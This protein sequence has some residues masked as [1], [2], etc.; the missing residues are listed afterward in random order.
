[1]KKLNSI[2]IIAYEYIDKIHGNAYFAV[3]IYVNGDERVLYEPFQYGYGDQYL[4]A[5]K[6]ALI[7]D[8]LLE[9]NYYGLVRYCRENDIILSYRIE[10]RKKEKEVREFGQWKD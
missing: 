8:G 2:K 1:M 10:R 3:R 9:P 6:Q 5:S 7:K 4:E